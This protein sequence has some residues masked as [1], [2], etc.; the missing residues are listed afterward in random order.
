M[1]KKTQKL[2]IIWDED[3]GYLPHQI[4]LDKKSAEY[5]LHT[6]YTEYWIHGGKAKIEEIEGTSYV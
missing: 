4:Y 2:F 6:L 3:N 1:K 5:I